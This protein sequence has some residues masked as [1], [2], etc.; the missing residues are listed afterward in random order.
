[1]AQSAS[2]KEE[3]LEAGEGCARLAIAEGGFLAKLQLSLLLLYA[4]VS[5]CWHCRGMHRFSWVLGRYF[6]PSNSAILAQGQRKYKIYL[7]DGYWAELLGRGFRY[8]EPLEELLSLVLSDHTVF[9]DCGANNGYWS[10]FA[11]QRI[12]CAGQI[13]AVEATS[14]PFNRLCE[15]M[16]LNE[17]RFTVIQRGIYSQSGLDL[18]FL[19]HPRRHAGNSCLNRCVGPGQIEY[20]KELVKSITIDEVLSA[21]LEGKDDARDLV[22]KLDVEGAERQAFQGATEAIKRGA[23][24]IYEDHPVDPRCRVSE[25]VLNTLGLHVYYVEQH[26]KVTEIQSCHELSK[27]KSNKALGYNYNLLAVA[28]A[29]SP[30]LQRILQKPR[31]RV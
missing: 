14:G 6:S 5:R 25:F 10:V 24:F 3:E 17:A 16:R 1:M 2:T 31:G 9:V 26:G 23:L 13:L 11:A 7:N 21:V 28:R 29:D 19:T 12:H 20:G 15:N 22:I 4:W 18:E 30:L 27:I 8:E